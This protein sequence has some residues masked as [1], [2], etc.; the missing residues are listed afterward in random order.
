MNFIQWLFLTILA[1]LAGMISLVI[2]LISWLILKLMKEEL[3]LK[4]KIDPL[5]KK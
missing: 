3:H 2:G 1:V 4:I 5:P